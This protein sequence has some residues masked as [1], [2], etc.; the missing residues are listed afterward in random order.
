MSWR[1]SKTNAQHVRQVNR[2]RK[3]L[4]KDTDVRIAQLA[5]SLAGGVR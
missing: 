2:I 5:R 1:R 3:A 4:A